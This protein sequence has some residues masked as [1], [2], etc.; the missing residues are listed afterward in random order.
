MTLKEP[1]CAGA[2]FMVH[3]ARFGF[4]PETAVSNAFQQVPQPGAAASHA[5]AVEN[6]FA[7][8]ASA[9]QAAGVRV[10]V[11]EDTPWP[12]K[13]DA[14]FPNNWVSFHHDGTVV[15]YPMLAPNR[16][17]ERRDELIDA[18]RRAGPYR[19]TRTIDLSGHEREGKYL[20][21]TGSLVLDRSAHVA[22]ACLSPR[23]DLDVLGDFARQLDYELVAFEAVDAQ[24][25][26]IYH[27]NVL[28]SVGTH[29]AVVCAASI[30]TPQHRVAV[31]TKLRATGREIVEISLEQMQCFA[32]NVLELAGADGPLIALSTTAWASL[33]PAQRQMLERH[34]KLLPVDVPTIER[35]GGGGVRCMLAE[36]HL[37]ARG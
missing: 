17:L 36:V 33:V 3:P 7:A 24:G 25:V 6:E 20:E 16:R 12:V 30:R 34:A 21:G 2:V 11:G 18:V 29:C 14:I 9:L 15:L 31:S 19:I 27:T 26:S 28:M 5:T 35:I 1:Q 8:L 13:P 32:G 23:T 4:N 10:I 37:P 22:Y